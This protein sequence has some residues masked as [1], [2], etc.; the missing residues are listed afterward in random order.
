VELEQ[1]AGDAGTDVIARV[2]HIFTRY[3]L[4]N[5]IA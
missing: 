1:G 5:N 2:L 4:A 3:A